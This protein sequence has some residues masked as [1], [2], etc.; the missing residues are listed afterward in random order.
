M[1]KKQKCVVI[2]LF[3]IVFFVVTY[4]FLKQ[5]SILQAEEFSYIYKLFL[6]G[7][8][9]ACTLFLAAAL[10]P[11]EQKKNISRVDTGQFGDSRFLTE[12]E[13]EEM[14]TKVIFSKRPSFLIKWIQIIFKVTKNNSEPGIV[15]ESNDDYFLV[16][17]T[18]KNIMIISPPGTGKT[19]RFLIPTLLMNALVEDKNKRSLLITD[20]KGELFNST[21]KELENNGYNVIAFNFRNPLNSNLFNM[22]ST[23]NFHIDNAN[24]ATTEQDEIKSLA[25]AEKNAKVLAGL[26]VGDNQNH[27][28][29]SKFFNDTSIGLLISI[30]LL[31]SKYSPAE[32]RHILS[33]LNIVIDLNGL[34]D[35]STD[36]NQTN[37]YSSLIDKL[38]EL[39]EEETAERLKMYSGAAV[40]ADNR[41]SMNIFSSTISS[42]TGFIDQ[43][44]EQ[45][46]TAQNTDFN[47]KNFI[48]KPTAV[49]MIIPD[50]NTTRHFMASLLIRNF[51]NEL[52]LISE[53]NGGELSRRVEYIL[54]EFGNT[55]PIKD[56]EVMSTA[57][58]GRGIR[59]TIALQVKKQLTK[60][61]GEKIAPIIEESFQTVIYGTL[62]SAAIKE[63]EEISKMAG[64]YT[65]TTY[66]TSQGNNSSFFSF[67]PNSRNKSSS[68]QLIKKN[69]IEPYE[70]FTMPE[71]TFLVFPHGS[72]PFLTNMEFIND[73]LEQK[74]FPIKFLD[75]LELPVTTLKKVHKANE[76]KI[77]NNISNRNLINK[78]KYN[79]KLFEF[80]SSEFI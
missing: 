10:L 71:G 48:E 20:I 64:S 41:T 44:I 4:F 1:S 27:S 31:V 3:S 8:P 38:I 9:I 57:V 32:E 19:K 62:S 14:F 46:I 28:G 66:S 60:T 18:D 42:L 63:A 36:V 59:I 76:E 12:E 25:E 26:I 67:L 80:T 74:Y 53:Q 69:L 30:I 17:S 75:S 61:Y 43:E 79:L 58:R 54:D 70:I 73:V 35:G 50:D 7:V 15:I 5:F 16:D 78:M 33:V 11:S 22:M 47:A 37:R 21:S 49:F 45:M 40:S 55:P 13:K 6:Y 2:P 56:F 68:E 39:G 24:Y 51:T 23:V 77:V 34:V 65:A 52:I 29:N 72:P